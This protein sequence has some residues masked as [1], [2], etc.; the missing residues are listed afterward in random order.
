MRQLATIRCIDDIQ[1]I[2]KADLIECAVI[3]GWKVVVKKGEFA[4]GEKAIYIEL[5]SFVPESL[6]PFL[7]KGTPEFLDGVPGNR[8]RTVILRGQVSQGLLLPMSTLSVEQAAVYRSGC[9]LDEILGIRKVE[10]PSSAIEGCSIKGWIPSFIQRTRQDRIQNLAEKM[11]QWKNELFVWEVTEK[12]DGESMTVF[13]NGDE[14]GVCTHTVELMNNQSHLFWAIAKRDR[15]IEKLKSLD[16]KLA[17]Q[18]EVIGAGMR[19]DEY[20]FVEPTFLVFDIF[21][22]DNH[23]Y[24]TPNERSGVCIR[25]KLRHVPVISSEFVLNPDDGIDVLLKLADGN[26]QLN[27]AA[28]EGLVF[29]REDGKASFK[30]ISNRFLYANE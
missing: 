2:A 10:H 11:E 3:G 9:T 30:V 23:R 29:K 17:L 24:L 16:R 14:S 8:L 26:S 1:P 13:V 22:I 27:H 5:D 6:A 25:L 18:G 15:L 21:D 12:I 19:N 28:R 7:T 4:K 20:G